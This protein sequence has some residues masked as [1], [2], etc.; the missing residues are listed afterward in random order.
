VIF[1]YHAFGPQIVAR[2]LS[3][4]TDA[5]VGTERVIF[6]I[7]ENPVYGAMVDG[8]EKFTR[9]YGENVPCTPNEVGFAPDDSQTVVIWRI[10]GTS[11]IP[12]R[13]DATMPIVITKTGQRAE[14]E[15]RTDKQLSAG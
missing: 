13:N 5:V 14:L 4:I 12:Q 15:D 2:M 10:G 1:M 3:R 8:I 9:W 11:A 7:Y 6:L